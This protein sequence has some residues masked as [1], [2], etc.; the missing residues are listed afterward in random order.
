MLHT[1]EKSRPQTP[2]ARYAVDSFP[3]ASSFYRPTF[4]I[5][6]VFAQASRIRRPVRHFI[7]LG[8][9]RRPGPSQPEHGPWPGRQQSTE[10]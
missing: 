5:V 7:R 9:A 2:H 6:Y 8:K 4:P 10:V 3:Q 1:A